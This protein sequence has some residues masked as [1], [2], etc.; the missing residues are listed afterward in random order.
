MSEPLQFR[1]FHIGR[2][3]LRASWLFEQEV[4][5]GVR[6]RGFPDYRR[7][8]GQVIRCL[9]V[10]GGAR[11]VDLA[12]RAQ[13]TKQGMGKLVASLQERGYVAR[14]PDPDDGR[15]QRVTLTVRGRALLREAGAVIAALEAQWADVVGEPRLTEVK[16]VLF[17]LTDALGPEDYL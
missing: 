7:T 14:A 5:A 1:R 4:D 2:A 8:D 16:Q 13:M 3:L 6:A 9:P 15:A 12:E 11:V 10:A 17:E